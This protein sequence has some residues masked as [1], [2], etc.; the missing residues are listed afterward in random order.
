MMARISV[1][2][3]ALGVVAAATLLDQD[4]FAMDAVTGVDW[5]AENEMEVVYD[6]FH[7]ANARARG[8]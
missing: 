6:F 7:P 2:K 8:T 5:I 1:R 3:A 4:G